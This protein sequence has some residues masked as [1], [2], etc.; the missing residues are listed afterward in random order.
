MT[1][2]PRLPD[3]GAD[4]QQPTHQTALEPASNGLVVICQ[5]APVPYNDVGVSGGWRERSN[6]RQT[7]SAIWSKL[8]DVFKRSELVRR[9]LHGDRTVGRRWPPWKTSAELPAVETRSK[10]VVVARFDRR[11][12]G[13]SKTRWSLRVKIEFWSVAELASVQQEPGN[14]NRE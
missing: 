12:T 13:L 7:C 14:R 1:R 9:R 3:P 8:P 10:P 5:V 4:Q 2:L 11:E 6:L